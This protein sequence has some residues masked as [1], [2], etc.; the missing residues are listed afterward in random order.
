M[1]YLHRLST[2]NNKRDNINPDSANNWPDMIVK[3]RQQT[4][5]RTNM[6]VESQLLPQPSTPRVAGRAPKRAAATRT[7]VAPAKNR[8]H[9]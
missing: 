2:N 5:G 3:L 1:V 9:R 6:E 7:K 4:L 8:P